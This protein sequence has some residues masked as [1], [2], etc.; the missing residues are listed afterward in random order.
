M[1]KRLALLLAI[2]ICLSVTPLNVSAYNGYETPVGSL[3]AMLMD[4][5]ELF[6]DGLGGIYSGSG[7]GSG[8]TVVPLTIENHP[9]DVEASANDTVIFTVAV[10]GG[11]KPYTYKWEY[12]KSG[13]NWI[14]ASGGNTAVLTRT[15]T[16]EDINAGIRYRCV[17]TDAKG[18]SVT[19]NEAGVKVTHNF[20]APIKITQQPVD[21]TVTV[22]GEAYFAVY[23]ENVT[24]PVTVKWETLYGK[25]WTDLSKTS[26]VI[27]TTNERST[28]VVSS[29]TEGIFK[30]RCIISDK[31]GRSITSDIVE[32]EFVKK[33]GILTKP[34]KI[35]K[36]PETVSGEFA[37]PVS[38]SVTA[39]GGKTPYSYQWQKQNS[40]GEWYDVSGQTNSSI[41]MEPKTHQGWFRVIVT[42]AAGTTVISDPAE[43][44][45]ITNGAGTPLTITKQP[46]S[47]TASK[48]NPNVVLSVTVSG[49]K[50]PY[51]YDWKQ[52]ISKYRMW[53]TVGKVQNL[54]VDSVANDGRSYHCVITD[55]DGNTVTTDNVMVNAYSG[56][57]TIPEK[58]E[59]RIVTQP[60]PASVNNLTAAKFTIEVKGGKAPYTYEWQLKVGPQSGFTWEKAASYAPTNETKHTGTVSMNVFEFGPLVRCIVTDADGEIVVSDSVR[61]AERLVIWNEVNDH[62]LDYIGQ[63]KEYAVT[64][65]GGLAP[66]N[67]TWYYKL[68]DK[69]DWMNYA[70]QHNT[71]STSSIGPIGLTG[72][73]NKAQIR[74]VI[75]DAAGNRIESIGTVTVNKTLKV[76]THPKSCI[77]SKGSSNVFNVA[78]S[79]GT[80]PYTYEWQTC[81]TARGA[82]FSTIIKTPN[83]K[84]T[85]DSFDLTF[86]QSGYL[87]E[88]ITD[89]LGNKVISNAAAITVQ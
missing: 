54:T 70:N 88:V 23:Y 28:I 89:S 32:A 75:T 49:G 33:S 35:T 44:I 22:G 21:D 80:G 87:R 37:K 47:V 59:F 20:L 73:T 16:S 31:S 36:Q 7:S 62:A 65:K 56:N 63:A 57:V 74:C 61:I 84:N 8:N 13:T 68:D 52:Y 69:G 72:F 1:K 4:A 58:T 85:T 64:V 83:T 86:Y 5:V 82:E 18:A 81:S 26:A 34:L 53:S 48:N 42:D 41:M 50:A 30:I 12:K 25:Q 9:Q 60:K 76:I 77:L 19:S 55:A 27:N 24:A 79:G 38:L 10:N 3:F 45:L 39:A 67:Y 14:T 11:V 43:V 46:V 29:P 15:L 17:I 2:L 71:I 78:I 51:S 40:K 66:Y 6:V